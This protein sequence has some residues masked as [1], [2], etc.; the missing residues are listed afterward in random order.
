MIATPL[1]GRALRFARAGR[2]VR[3]DLPLFV[4]DALFTVV[5]YLLAVVVRFDGSVPSK[6]WG[7]MV[8][9]SAA[10][11]LCH[12]GANWAWGLYGQVWRHASVAEARRLA[13]AGPTALVALL[14]SSTTWSTRMPISVMVLGAMGATFVA[15]AMRFQSRLFSVHRSGG[16]FGTRVIVVGAGECGGAIVREMLRSPASGLLPVAL[17][18]DEMRKRGRSLAGIPIVGGLEDLPEVAERVS[19][20]QVLLAIP[21]ATAPLVRRVAALAEAAGLALKVIPPVEELIGGQ[22]SVRDVRDL[23]IEDLLG[24]EQVPTDLDSVRSVLRGKT[25]LITGAGGSIG[26]E[27]ARQVAACGPAELL[28]LDHDETHLYDTAAS[29]DGESVSLLADIRDEATI[30]ALFDQWLPEVVFHAAAHKHV[31]LLESHPCEAAATNVV[32]TWNVTQAAAAIG[33][34]HLVFISTDKAVRPSSVMGASKRIGEQVVIATAPHGSRWC[35]VRFGN[36][37]GSRGSVIPT[38]ARQIAAGGPVTVTDPRMTRFFMS[39]PEAVQLVLQAAAFCEGG[40]VFMLEMGEAVNILDL[41]ERMIRLSGRTVG[42]DIAVRIT[43]MRPGEKLEEELSAPGEV[44]GPTQHPAIVRLI[45]SVVTENEVRL[46]VKE[47]EVR[48]RCRDMEGVR[49]ALFAFA[50]DEL[51]EAVHA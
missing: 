28:L 13:L 16:S 29:I 30:R 25:V 2:K 50:D 24:R 31:P 51:S 4:L 12:L 10:V 39:I 7:L 19:A 43:G 33:V 35:G 46:R 27:I 8:P 38:F 47:L 21:S 44:A 22:V 34:R 48:A 1:T 18:D 17:L 42:T 15:A 40:E 49:A 11:L 37:L 45:P 36:V 14:V 41:A 23:K 6:Y 26:S 9:F 5:S 3:A 20:T 32:G